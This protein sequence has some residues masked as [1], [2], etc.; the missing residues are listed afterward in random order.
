MIC[1]AGASAYAQETPKISVFGGYSYQLNN[2]GQNTCFF[3]CGEGASGLHGYAASATYNATKN[4]GLEANFSGHNGS[5]LLASEAPTSSNNGYVEHSGQDIYTYT[6]GPKLTLPIGHFAAYTHFLVGGMHAHQAFNEVCVP[7]TGST[8]SGT[9]NTANFKG[10]GMA[11]KTGAGLDWNRGRWGIRV[12][13]VDYIHSSVWA[14]GTCSSGCGPAISLNLGTN[15]FELAT[16]LT[17][18]FK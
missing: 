4:I 13:E 7:A 11:F 18:N 17:V 15:N 2:L 16:G 9:P 6:F 5:P 12:L 14:T 1:L 8:C 10:T 3:T